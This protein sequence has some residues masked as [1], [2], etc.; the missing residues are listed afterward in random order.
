MTATLQFFTVINNLYEGVETN[1]ISP[2]GNAPTVIPISGTVTFTAV[3]ANAH[4]I[5]Q[6]VSTALDSTI[7]FDPIQGRFSVN[8]VGGTPDGV[9][10][11]LNGTAGVELVDN[12]NLGLT[13]LYYQ[14]QYSN[15]VFDGIGQRLIN[16]FFFAAPG[17]GAQIDLSTVAQLAL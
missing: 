11:S 5:Q 12:V 16:S 6:V 1:T 17:N 8:T 15:V 10:R 4:V 2:S 14:V 13:A 7:L 9:L 3:D